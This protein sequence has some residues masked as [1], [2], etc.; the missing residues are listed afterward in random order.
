MLSQVW[1]E[2]LCQ[3]QSNPRLVLFATIN[4]LFIEVSTGSRDL[5]SPQIQLGPGDSETTMEQGWG[6]RVQAVLEVLIP[7][8]FEK[9]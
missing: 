1:L 2:Q 8:Y 5:K 4:L 3:E 7:F 6:C 9:N